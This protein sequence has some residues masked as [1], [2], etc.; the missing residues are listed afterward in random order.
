M[1]NNQRVNLSHPRTLGLPL[2]DEHHGSFFLARINLTNQGNQSGSVQPG[3]MSHPKHT[4]NGL[5]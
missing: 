5:V 3:S 4:V 1:L 2:I